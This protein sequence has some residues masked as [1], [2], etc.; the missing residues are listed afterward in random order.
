MSFSHA[1]FRSFSP[2]ITEPSVI[3]DSTDLVAQ[4]LNLKFGLQQFNI[5]HFQ[6]ARATAFVAPH[7]SSAE[8]ELKITCMHVRRRVGKLLFLLHDLRAAWQSFLLCSRWQHS[9]R[10]F[11][12]SLAKQLRKLLF[13]TA[14]FKARRNLATTANSSTASWAFLSHSLVSLPSRS[15]RE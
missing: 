9:R 7:F 15:C 11:R 1:P 13:H 3:L 2:S 4:L 10:A 8:P 12:S 6:L 14:P 5:D